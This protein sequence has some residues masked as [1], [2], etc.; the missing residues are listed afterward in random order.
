MSTNEIFLKELQEKIGIQKVNVFDNIYAR[1]NELN[2]ALDDNS[3]YQIWKKHSKRIERSS[4][5]L[6]REKKINVFM[7]DKIVAPVEVQQ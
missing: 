5:E 4:K 6:K 3:L 1:N 2:V 7:H